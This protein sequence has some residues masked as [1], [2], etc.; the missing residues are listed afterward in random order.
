MATD[1]TSTRRAFLKVG[2]IAAAPLGVAGAAAA[3]TEHDHR[4][5]LVRLK[6]ETAIRDLHQAWLRRVNTGEHGQAAALFADPKAGLHKAVSRIAPDL[7]AAP[8]AITLAP[9]RLTASGVFHCA[10]ETMAP[11]PLDCTLAQMAAA[12][13][14]GMISSVERRVV[15][16]RY[17]KAGDGWA[18]EAVRFEPV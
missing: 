11:R 6:D 17:V 14:E 10:V 13:G 4:A 7:A 5:E 9:D 12:Q 16:A 15:K 18:I 2:A 3:I 1:K 8:D